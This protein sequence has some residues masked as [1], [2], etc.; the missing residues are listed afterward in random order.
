[1]LLSSGLMQS[2]A[3]LLLPAFVILLPVAVR[4]AAASRT[5]FVSSAIGAT[6]ASAWFGAYMLTVFE[7]A[8]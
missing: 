3:R 6:L 7:Y 8:I 4:L 2:R 5:A 1:V